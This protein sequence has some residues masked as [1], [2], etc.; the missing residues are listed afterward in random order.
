MTKTCPK[1]T[2]YRRNNKYRIPLENI[3]FFGNFHSCD[4]LKIVQVGRLFNKDA[5]DVAAI[6]Q[7]A[8]GFNRFDISRRI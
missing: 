7:E 6:F 5:K 2:F 1:K 8:D 3:Y 4:V